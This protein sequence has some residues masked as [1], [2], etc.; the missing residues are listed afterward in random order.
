MLLD[1]SWY[2]DFERNDNDTYQLGAPDGFGTV[3]GVEISKGGGNGLCLD[4][5]VLRE[6]GADTVGVWRHDDLAVHWL[7]QKDDCPSATDY[8]LG[9]SNVFGLRY[10]QA[11]AR[12]IPGATAT[13]VKEPHGSQRHGGVRAASAPRDE[14][15]DIIVLGDGQGGAFPNIVSDGGGEDDGETVIMGD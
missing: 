4:R 5:I 7:D 9:N 13:A 2:N 1:K 3:T 12:G 11:Q 15:G 14:D 8:C 10:E 6:P